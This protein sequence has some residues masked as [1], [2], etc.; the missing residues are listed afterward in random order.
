MNTTHTGINQV[1][2]QDNFYIFIRYKLDIKDYIRFI[3]EKKP[4]YILEWTINN[5]D[6]FLLL[7]TAVKT[8]DN[9]LFER[10]TLQ[11][12][13]IIITSE[14]F[15]KYELDYLTN[16]TISSLDV[17]ML[18]KLIELFLNYYRSV[19]AFPLWNKILFDSQI[20]LC[21]TKKCTISPE[22]IF[23][24][25][26]TIIYKYIKLLCKYKIHYDGKYPSYV[27]P[28]ILLTYISPPIKSLPIPLEAKIN[29]LTISAK[30]YNLISNRE[31]ATLIL[32]AK[33]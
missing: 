16:I 2:S 23:V 28:N 11:Y 18:E 9:I 4:P 22:T 3:F 20:H 29:I 24:S 26:H 8:G 25:P 33:N 30:D 6:P 17:S 21:Y 1:I 12:R 19:T 5:V 27:D 14:T 7:E 15:L 32:R 13:F 10:I 31:V